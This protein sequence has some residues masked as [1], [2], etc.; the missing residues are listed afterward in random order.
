[1]K[2]T[3]EVKDYVRGLYGR[4]PAPIDPE[5]VKKILGDEKPIEGRPADYIEPELEREKEK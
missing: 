2:V 3:R 5:L 1:L 4:P